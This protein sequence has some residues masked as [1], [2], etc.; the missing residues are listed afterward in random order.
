MD[1]KFK[2]KKILIFGLGLNQGGVGSAK[3]F[4]EEGAAV[5]VTD[6]KNAEILAPSLKQLKKYQS[7]SYT[8]G[9]HK[10]EDI[11]WADLIIK[12]PAI[13]PGNLY[14]KY[15]LHKNKEIETDMGIFLRYV[16]PDQLIGVTGTKGKS[17]TSSLIYEVLKQNKKDVI[18][19]GNIGVSVLDTIPLIKKNTLVV[20]EIS[21]FQLEAFKIKKISPK[22]AVITN[23]TPDHLNYYETLEDYTQAKKIIGKFQNRTDYLFLR[24]G[25][26]VTTQTDFLNDLDSQ[27]I[28]Y[29]KEDLPVDFKPNLLGIHNLENIAAAFSVAKTFDI[30]EKSAL[31]ILAQ[32]K[33]V[34]FRMELV[35]VWD[36]IS[37]YNDTAATSPE[38]G[39][40][41]IQTFPGCILI[42]GGMN[43]GM[44]YAEYAKTLEGSVKAAFFLEG[45]STEEIKKQIDKKSLIAGTYNNLE[46][47]LTEVKKVV[48]QGDIIL[49]SPA[50]TSFN[51][52][53]NEFDR[54]RKFNSAVGKIFP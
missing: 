3:F 18:L 8:L 26:P 30:N 7:I 13:K 43:K 50:A 36:G 11:D 54:G 52:F 40:R 14:I 44:D 17:T 37:I 41:A 15:A 53:Q 47:L 9:E 12:N 42:A 24:E 33:G 21:S 34:P 2:G 49:F 19:A 20:L 46:K 38:A 27:I 32:F 25:D 31:N 28:H 4:A 51:L 1:N 6:L 23:I 39:I 5:R 29:S 35:K 10:Y 45:D 16:Q 48:K 22:W